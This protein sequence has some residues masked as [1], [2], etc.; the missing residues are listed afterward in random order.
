MVDITWHAIG[1]MERLSPPVPEQAQSP[2][3]K[4]IEDLKAKRE[5]APL[6]PKPIETAPRFTSSEVGAFAQEVG[7]FFDV[8]F[9][10]AS[11]YGLRA[12]HE[13][14]DMDVFERVYRK[15]RPW[16]EKAIDEVGNF[17]IGAGMLGL[18][19]ATEIDRELRDVETP[20]R[21]LI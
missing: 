10:E 8:L 18:G 1:C 21:G 9:P 12:S 13:T 6:Y 20:Q 17:M 15:T 19:L 7:P 5:S 14:S 4:H 16:P 2:L 11:L 3:G